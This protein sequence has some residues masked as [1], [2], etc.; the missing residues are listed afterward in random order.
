MNL[1]NFLIIRTGLGYHILEVLVL[2]VFAG[3]REK[4]DNMNDIDSTRQAHKEE[5]RSFKNL[6]R[7]RLLA[8]HRLRGVFSG[9]AIRSRYVGGVAQRDQCRGRQLITSLVRF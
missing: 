6:K 7:R 1:K 9:D 2:Q 8:D 3:V 5:K 4:D